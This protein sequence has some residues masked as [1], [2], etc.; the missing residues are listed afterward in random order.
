MAT[1]VAVAIVA[2]EETAAIEVIVAAEIGEI[3]AIAAGVTMAI[4]AN[5]HHNRSRHLLKHRLRR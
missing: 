5:G 1:A 4:R 3:A 2:T